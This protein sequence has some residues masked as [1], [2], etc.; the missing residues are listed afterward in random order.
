MALLISS[1]WHSRRF[2]SFL[3][4]RHVFLSWLYETLKEGC[5]VFV[6]FTHFLISP[7]ILQLSLLLSL[8]LLLSNTSFLLLLIDAISHG[9]EPV[10][11]IDKLIKTFGW[12]FRLSWSTCVSAMSL[13]LGERLRRKL[14][15]FKPIGIWILSYW[16]NLIEVLVFKIVHEFVKVL[17]RV[18]VCQFFQ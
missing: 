2:S 16:C 7:R 6:L 1:H 15:C 17:P 5:S 18:E 12:W 8:F 11:L 10:D 4:S 13:A 9:V 14:W 3:K